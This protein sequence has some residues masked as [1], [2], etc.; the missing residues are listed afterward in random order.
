MVEQRYD[1]GDLDPL[2]VGVAGFLLDWG[3]LDHCSEALLAD[4]T[5]VLGT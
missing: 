2:C 1:L 4:K 5:G 3:I